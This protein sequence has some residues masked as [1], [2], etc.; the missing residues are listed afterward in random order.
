MPA[1]KLKKY[2]REIP[3]YPQKGILFYDI[4]TLLSHP[5]A[6][7]QAIDLMCQKVSH[8]PIDKIVGIES[9]GFIFASAMA[10]K[11]GV[12]FVPIRK[13]GKLPYKTISHKY[14]LEY[15]QDQIEI[16]ADAVNR[17]EKVLLVDDL[18]ATGGTALA[19]VK[20]LDKLNA[21]LLGLSFLIELSFLPGRKKLKNHPIFS[22]LS[23]NQ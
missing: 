18:L 2:I 5:Q 21:D 6:F 3:D 4:T 23:Y 12:G 20:L 16:H 11:L 17:H 19:A 15:G 22:I 7:S 10:Q 1:S 8:L 13:K 9:R 14:D